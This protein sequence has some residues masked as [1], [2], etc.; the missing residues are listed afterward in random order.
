MSDDENIINVSLND[1]NNVITVQPLY[2]PAGNGISSVVKTASSGLV[3]TY[4]INFTN[5]AAT[6]FNVNNGR[7]IVSCLR[8]SHSNLTDT[9]TITYN[10][11]TTSTFDV[12]NDAGSVSTVAANMAHI[13]TVI[14]NMSDVNSVANKI[15]SVDRVASSIINVDVCAYYMDDLE[16]IKDNI[17]D[18]QTISNDFGTIQ[19]VY[20]DIANINAVAGDISTINS[21]AGDLTNIDSVKNNAANINTVAGISGN[22]TTVAES[23]SNIN[24]VYGAISNINSVAADLT[25]INNVAADL[26]N[27][28]AAPTNANNSRIWAEGTDEQV[29]A[30]GG[31]HSAKTWSTYSSTV[32]NQDVRAIKA[33]KEG[34]V[35][36]AS[37]SDSTQSAFNDVVSYAHSTFDISKFTQVGT[38]TVSFDGITSSLNSSNYLNTGIKIGNK[39]FRIT[40]KVNYTGTITGQRIFQWGVGT[41]QTG[42]VYVQNNTNLNLGI[43]LSDDTSVNK[44]LL[45]TNGDVLIEFSFD[46][47][48]YQLSAS[49]DNGANWNSTNYTSSLYIKNI[50]TLDVLVGHNFSSGHID[51]KYFSIEVDKVPVFI[52]NN[53]DLDVIKAN[54]YTAVGSPT[55][56]TDG[57]ASGFSA[58]DYI[59][60]TQVIGQKPFKIYGAA[61]WANTVAGQRI[62]QLGIGTNTTM[63]VFVQNGALDLSLKL[64]DDSSVLKTL[65]S[66]Y[67]VN[68][69][70]EVEFTGT[71]YIFRASSD[72]GQTWT[73]ATETSSL[74]IKNIDTLNLYIGNNASNI[75][76][77]LNTILVYTDG[78]FVYQPC[79]KIPFV[80]SKTGSKVVNDYYKIRVKDLYKLEGLAPYYVIDEANKKFQLPQGELYGMLGKAYKRGFPGY[81]SGISKTSAWTADS[82]GFVFCK[83]ENV[84]DSLD[85]SV[86]INSQSVGNYKLVDSSAS[87]TGSI[88]VPISKGDVFSLDINSNP[89]SVTADYTVKFYPIKGV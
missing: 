27:I 42:S 57:I 49:A 46:G 44:S 89:N 79:L 31:V 29:Q 36:E 73:S 5:G 2:G 10:D 4:T 34:S 76:I 82:D 3:D 56:S 43:T 65:S 71:Q 54:N 69:M 12:T 68:V 62:L 86:T 70:F 66:I 11:G 6:G 81:A 51:L 17:Y 39:P 80:W 50:D 47:S 38:P 1:N 20:S 58:N 26:S 87:S 55:I 19:G 32:T 24:S 25:N 22:V 35:I 88:F 16:M 30:L 61:T 78:D 84:T 83:F 45:N 23:I 53:T 7:G 9:Y 40:A 72:G 48:K 59:N 18:I 60:T 64:S 85:Y 52:S 14:A 77:D 13:N 41:N 75:T 63:S 28:N 21:V 8:T 67:G 33:N 37:T 74:Y 15:N